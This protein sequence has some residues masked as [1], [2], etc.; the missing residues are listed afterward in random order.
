M[1]K[2]SL[3][4]MLHYITL[5]MSWHNKVLRTQH[6]HGPLY[7]NCPRCNSKILREKNA[8][9]LSLQILVI[10]FR[11]NRKFVLEILL[12]ILDNFFE[13]SKNPSKKFP[14]KSLI[15]FSECFL[16]A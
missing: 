13:K 12:Q 7:L 15:K 5:L 6:H 11:K 2:L 8:Y 14:E 3:Q 16:C 9:K 4:I 1:V 10:L